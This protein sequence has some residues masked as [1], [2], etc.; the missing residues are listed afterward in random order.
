MF[1]LTLF[2]MLSFPALAL[3]QFGVL[4]RAGLGDFGPDL[5]GLGIFFVCCRMNES[6]A[7][8]A[9]FFFGLAVDTLA[10][11]RLGAM[12]IGSMLAVKTVLLLRCWFPWR[13]LRWQMLWAAA[14]AGGIHVWAWGTGKL[15]GGPEYAAPRLWWCAAIA[16][17]S[18]LIWP[19]F[20]L[21]LGKLARVSGMPEQES[22]V[23]PDR[24]G[25]LAFRRSSVE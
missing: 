7:V 23:E 24:R 19:L 20:N 14:F 15:L 17:N 21:F 22:D 25:T 16:V 1:R 4:P 18:A 3:L 2:M 10:S 6:E 8:F 13:S 5:A 11:P 12:A 9:A